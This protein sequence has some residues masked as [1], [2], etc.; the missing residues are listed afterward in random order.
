MHFLFCSFSS[1]E[2]ASISASSAGADKNNVQLNN[3][4]CLGIL[5]HC[6]ANQPPWNTA[7]FFPV[8]VAIGAHANFSSLLLFIPSKAKKKKSKYITSCAP[9]DFLSGKS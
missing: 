9:E 1:F 4:H 8:A 2:L 3:F 6:V 5:H 7:M